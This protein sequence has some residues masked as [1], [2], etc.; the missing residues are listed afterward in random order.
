MEERIFLATKKEH[1]VGV[2]FNATNNTATRIPTIKYEHEGNLQGFADTRM[3]AMSALIQVIEKTDVSQL[4][5]VVPIFVNQQL[6][7]FIE[8]GTYKFWIKTGK[9]QSGEEVSAT[10][11]ELLK[12]F[13][14]VWKEKGA[15]FVIRDIFACRIHDTAKADPSKLARFKPYSQ[16]NDYYCRWCWDEIAKL[17]NESVQASMASVM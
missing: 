17:Y 14:N 8:K 2:I 12:S 11:I 3:S 13:A 4:T 5:N 1:T 15:D 10:E 16:Q 9:K 7:D 6:H